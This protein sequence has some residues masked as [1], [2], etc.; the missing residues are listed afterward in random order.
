MD[1]FSLP[2]LPHGLSIRPA[3]PSDEPFLTSLYRS[4]RDDLLN[5]LDAEQDFIEDL[6]ER[7][8]Q[9]QTVGYGGSYPNA[10]YFIVEKLD[11]AVGRVSIDFGSNEVHILDI[12]FIPQARG[13]GYGE[14]VISALQQVAGKIFVP[15]SL[16]V[17]SNNTIAKH[18]YLK[19]GFQVEELQPPH[20]RWVW[21][22]TREYR[23]RA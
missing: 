8:F 1:N 22:P 2:P 15:L 14:S 7:Q 9:A 4:T 3:R 23:I 13:K 17:E 19:L 20:E 12:A 18:L 5:F 6:I 16:V 11:Q 21:Y 10:M